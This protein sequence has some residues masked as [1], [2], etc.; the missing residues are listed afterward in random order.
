ML[1][2][3]E[4]SKKKLGILERLEITTIKLKVT[5]ML[6]FLQKVEIEKDTIEEKVIGELSIWAKKNNIRFEFK[7][8]QKPI[9]AKSHHLLHMLKGTRHCKM[10]S[11][12]K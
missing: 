5:L 3:R 8:I 11:F 6:M 4:T 10:L 1:M 12:S 2:F 7:E 9:Y